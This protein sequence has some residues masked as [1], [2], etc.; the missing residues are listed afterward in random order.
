MKPGIPSMICVLAALTGLA[1][2]AMADEKD[3]GHDRDWREPSSPGAAQA[4]QLGPRPLFLVD[5]M[6][7]SP[8]KRRLASCENRTMRRNDFSIGHRGAA[9][10][11]PEHT[12]ESYI[13][14]ARMGA[15]IIECDVTFT[16]DQEL[17]CRHAQDDLHATTNILAIPELAAK[18]TRPFTPATLDADGKL[19]SP[20]SAECRTSDL[21]LAEF[22]RLRGKMDGFDPRGRSVAEYM[23]GPADFRTDLYSGPSSG[24]LMSHKESIALFERLGVKMTPELKR[25]VVTMPFDGLSQEDY[26]QKL[27]D[28]YKEARVP[29]RNV[30]PQSFDKAD[31]L[32]W[33]RHEPRFGRQAVYLDDANTLSELPDAAEL[34]Q[35]KA[36][37]IKIWAPPIFALLTSDGAG[38]IVPSQAATDARAA[39]LDIITW[40]LER[41]GILAD[42]N[43][44]FYYQ[45]LDAAVSRE[46]DTLRVLDALARKVQVLGVFSDWPATTTYYANCMDL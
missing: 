24:T 42:G 22:K 1:G 23:A 12:R 3:H 5:D 32:Y 25:P 19:V 28:E 31:V 17:V 26:A 4:I 36:E 2:F 8:L 7:D 35:Y 34:A 9:M 16:R 14:A 38:E 18:C 30:Y 21:T 44:G 46:G 40:T 11:F 45:G 13:A 6:A 15:G 41:S 10:Q 20:A 27:I 37:G 33:I 29:A 43:N 39:G